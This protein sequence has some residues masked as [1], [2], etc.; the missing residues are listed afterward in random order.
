MSAG[1]FARGT[2]FSLLDEAEREALSALGVRRSFPRDAILMFENEPSARVMLLL[3]G[4]VKVTRI[5]ED[6]REA[7]LSLRD[8][9]DVL[10][11]LSFIDGEPH[12]ATITALEHVE[13]LVLLDNV[14]R[15]HLETTPRVAVALLAVVARSLREA[16]AQRAQFAASDTL[17][18][19]AT[20]ITEL[21]DRYGEATDG[22]ITVDS[23][24]TREELAA[25]TGASRAGVAQAL[26]TLRELGWIETER[27]KLIVRDSQALRA[28]AA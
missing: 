2:F 14:F 20:R 8:P 16:T 3:S 21:A 24:L 27:R 7:V 23:P 1:G 5:G 15:T 28:R 25:W 17:G 10:G 13:A 9:G 19:L 18:R 22:T 12:A 26:H 4:R 11:E 6:G